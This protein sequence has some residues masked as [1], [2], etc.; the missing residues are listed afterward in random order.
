MTASREAIAQAIWQTYA[1][2]TGRSLPPG[3]ADKLADAAL[4]APEPPAEEPDEA[5]IREGYWHI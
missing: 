4:T 5:T 1:I 3:L 2:E